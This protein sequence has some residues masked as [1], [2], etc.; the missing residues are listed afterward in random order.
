MAKELCQSEN[1]LSWTYFACE[2]FL[3]RYFDNSG[4]DDGGRERLTMRK[5]SIE[6]VKNRE[7]LSVA[8]WASNPGLRNARTWH[9]LG[10]LSEWHAKILVV[11][12]DLPLSHA[13]G[14]HLEETRTPPLHQ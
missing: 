8:V 7:G 6:S 9:V 14:L 11:S 1:S 5:L 4:D 3:R 13:L 10:V 2:L 12:D